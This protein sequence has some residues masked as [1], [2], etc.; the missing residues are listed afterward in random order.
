MDKR[1][2]LK[3]LNQL[4]YTGISAQDLKLFMQDLKKVMKYDRRKTDDRTCNSDSYEDYD[5]DSEN[6]SPGYSHNRTESSCPSE[7]S[8]ILENLRLRIAPPQRNVFEDLYRT[9]TVASK[10][11]IVAPKKTISLEIKRNP[12]PGME[13]ASV[14]VSSSLSSVAVPST[15]RTFTTEAV[16]FPCEKPLSP[17]RPTTSS[18]LRP[19]S[20]FIRPK[21]VTKVH[22]NDPVALY[23]KYQT[24]WKKLK[25]PGESSH[26]DLRWAIREQLMG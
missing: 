13:N 19:K 4:G 17:K 5:G 2:V 22:K 26:S 20:S 18:S 15:V 11:R 14:Q 12:M 10:A 9:D 21:L 7:D 1:E 25:I 23:Q 3:F 6:V 24:E 8:E 16:T